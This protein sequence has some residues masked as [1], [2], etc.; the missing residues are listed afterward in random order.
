MEAASRPSLELLPDL[1]VEEARKVL[2]YRNVV[3]VD[4]RDIANL[5]AEHAK[6]ALDPRRGEDL[7]RAAE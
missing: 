7:A 5:W 4:Y 6:L 2:G 3:E 1:P